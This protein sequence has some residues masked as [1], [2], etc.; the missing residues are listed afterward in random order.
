EQKLSDLETKKLFQEK[1][2][3]FQK[4]LKGKER[5]IFE[6]RLLSEHP[7]TLEQIGKR[8]G[9]TRERIRQLEVKLIQKLKGFLQKD[10]N[11]MSDYHITSGV[12]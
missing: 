7:E 4:T 1:L 9:I 3:E 2:R 12:N 10:G 8:Y 5:D 6:N 11:D